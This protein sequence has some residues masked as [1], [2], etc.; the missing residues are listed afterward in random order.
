MAVQEIIKY[1]FKD[2]FSVNSV[3]FEKA[4]TI[5]HNTQQN[6]YSIYWVQEGSGTYNIDFEQYTFTDNVL[7]FL[8]PGQVFT[9]DSV[10][11]KTA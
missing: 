6:A 3:Q 2:T 7:F 4:C 9:V 1:S 10:Q 8:S 5:D 11:I